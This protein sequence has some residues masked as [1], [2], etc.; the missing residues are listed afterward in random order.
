MASSIVDVENQIT[1]ALGQMLEEEEEEE[2]EEELQNVARAG[3]AAF[4]LGCH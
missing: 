1:K 4:F 2:E 3:W